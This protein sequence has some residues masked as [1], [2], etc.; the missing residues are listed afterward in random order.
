M[1][2]KYN[3]GFRT[4]KKCSYR[5][6][7]SPLRNKA[8]VLNLKR[9]FWFHGGVLFLFHGN[10]NQG[11]YILIMHVLV[12]KEENLSVESSGV[13]CENITVKLFHQHKQIKYFTKQVHSC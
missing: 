10:P 5:I 1:H 3:V 4:I 8:T 6:F 2:S 7:E 12:S 9:L 11:D 13:K